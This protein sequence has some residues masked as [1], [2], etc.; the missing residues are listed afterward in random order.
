ML[1]PRCATRGPRNY[2]WVY[3]ERDGADAK[4]H[5]EALK[6][7]ISGWRQTGGDRRRIK[8]V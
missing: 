7:L 8:G 5:G 2:R 1:Q 3:A 4:L 6:R